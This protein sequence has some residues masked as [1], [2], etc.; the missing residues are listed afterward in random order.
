MDF[1]TNTK[2]SLTKMARDAASVDGLKTATG[3]TKECSKT[4]CLT[5][6]ADSS[7][8]TVATT[9]ENT[10]TTT[11]TVVACSWMQPVRS[12]TRSGLE[13]EKTI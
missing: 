4:I 3:S 9:S 1:H 12:R 5:D 10:K 13:T 7:T 8:T 11:D 6:S 2:V